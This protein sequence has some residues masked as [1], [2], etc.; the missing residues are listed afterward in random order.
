MC[1]LLKFFSTLSRNYLIEL[2]DRVKEINENL[3]PGTYFK[4]KGD[5]SLKLQCLYRMFLYCS[6]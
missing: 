1:A 3:F 2:P 4:G 5:A 6:V